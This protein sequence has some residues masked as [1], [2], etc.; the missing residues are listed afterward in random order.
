IRYSL[1]AIRYSLFAIRYSLFAMQQQ[2]SIYVISSTSERPLILLIV[3]RYRK[4]MF[5]RIKDSIVR[6]SE[7]AR[8]SG[9]DW[10]A[11]SD[12]ISFRGEKLTME[13]N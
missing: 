6:A 5:K 11:V 4:S 2:V 3:V 13:I 8:K 9:F 7:N 12:W 1:F 10:P